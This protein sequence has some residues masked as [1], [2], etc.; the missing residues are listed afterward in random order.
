MTEALRT[1]V[2]FCDGVSCR[3]V[4]EGP[5]GLTLFGRTRDRPDEMASVAFTGLAP[6]DLPEALEDATVEQ[7][8][9]NT[10]RIA[11]ASREWLVT[12]SAVH[13]HREVSTAFYRVVVPRTPPWSKRLFWRIVLGLA[14]HPT[15]RR[16]L[17]ALRRR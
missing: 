1:I 15:G 14:S 2:R 8:D 16:L 17:L 5:L 10:Y 12:A 9:A 4:P 7:L 6:A 13:L 3:R 11:C